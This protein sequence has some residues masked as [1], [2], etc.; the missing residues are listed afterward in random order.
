MLRK[1]YPGDSWTS[2]FI[3]RGVADLKRDRNASEV[4]RISSN[5]IVNC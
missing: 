4:S 5:I 2:L 3:S 1:K